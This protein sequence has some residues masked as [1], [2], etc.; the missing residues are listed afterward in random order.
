MR[1]R[2]RKW[3]AGLLASALLMGAI[4]LYAQRVHSVT[5]PEGTKLTLRL[6]NPLS[7]KTNRGGDR[8]TADVVSPVSY[9]GKVVIPAGSV[10]A[11]RVTH[12]KRPGRL[13]GR[14]EMSLRFESLRFPNGREE[15][16]VARL[17]STDR[18]TKGRVDREGSLKGQ[19]SPKKDAA[20][21]GAAGGAG[22]GIGAVI[23]GGK[24]TAIGAGVGALAGLITLLATRGKDLDVPSGTEFHIVLDRPLHLPDRP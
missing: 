21:I 15:S 4:A 5:L 17:S 8:F 6:N 19:G 13:T 16:L 9:H 12:L 10:V 2:N 14:G 24:G 11:G 22:A 20:V 1:V 3:F 18:S 7:T 23:G